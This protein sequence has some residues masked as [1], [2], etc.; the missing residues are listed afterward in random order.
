M[1]IEFYTGIRSYVLFAEETAYGTAGTPSDSDKI[2]R[3]TNASVSMNNN[4]IRSRGAGEGINV[5]STVLG[6]FDVSGSLSW[7]INDFD[8]FQYIVGTNEGAGSVG[9]PFE[10]TER[11]NFGY[12]STT[13]P[14]LTLEFGNDGNT[15]DQEQTVD[16]CFFDS[17]TININQGQPITATGSYRGRFMTRGT[18]IVTVTSSALRTFVANNG[19]FD[20]DAEP[21]DYSSFSLT[22]SYA[23]PTNR[24]VSDRFLKQPALGPRTYDFN[25]TLRKKFDSTASTLSGTEL[26][27]Y[28]LGGTNTPLSVGAVTART[29]NLQI[30]EGAASGDRVVQIQL[31]NCFFDTWDDSF[32]RDG[33]FVEL[34]VA[35]HAQNG[36][37][38]GGVNVPIR[39]WTI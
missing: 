6:N 30:D 20:I 28:F 35:G 22:I 10:I 12:S 8:F 37:A 11:S 1:A 15:D 4:F 7:E 36:T 32:T 19:D 23:N 39:Y 13:I 33:D 27:S 5:Q 21:L 38:D 3:I 31:S 14:T 29:I 18:S 9:D 34:S 24:G 16:G 26:L 25:M 2:G 17:M